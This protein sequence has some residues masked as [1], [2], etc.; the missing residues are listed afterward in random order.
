MR[1][2]Q[3]GQ[4]DSEHA[5]WATAE[6]YH[7]TP[8]GP[9][10]QTVT[11]TEFDADNNAVEVE[12]G[13]TTGFVHEVCL[14]ILKDQIKSKLGQVPILLSADIVWTHVDLGTDGSGTWETRR[15]LTIWDQGDS[16]NWRYDKSLDLDWYLDK[17]HIVRG[18]DVEAA[19]SDTGTWTHVYGNGNFDISRMPLRTIVE[20]ALRDNTHVFAHLSC[21]HVPGAM[22]VGRTQVIFNPP[23]I[24]SHRP[25]LA[26]AYLY[27]IE[28]YRDDGSG[29]LDLASPVTDTPGDEYYLGAVEPG[30]TGVAKKCHLRNYSDGIQQ[31]EIFDDHPEYTVPI[32]RVGTSQLD[33][34]GLADN[35]VSQLYTAIFYSSTQFEVKAVAYRDNAISLHPTINADASWRGAVGSDFTAPE[36]GLIIPSAAWQ[37]GT[38]LDDEYEAGVRGNTTD[39]AW[40]ADSNDQ[41]EITKDNAGSPDATAWRPCLGRRELTRAQVTID[42]TTKMIPTR[43]V[44]PANW[45]VDTKAFIMDET[46][47]NEGEI[48]SVQEMSVGAASHVG[49]GLDDCTISGNFNGVWTDTL[50]IRIDGTGTPDTF[51]ISYDGGSTYPTQDVPMTGAAQLLKDGLYVTFAATT[52]HTLTDYWNS[53]IEAWAIELKALTANSNV[54]NSGSR[55]ATT[56]PI[57]DVPASTFS[58]VDAASGVSEGTPARIWVASTVGMSPGQD[59]FIQNPVDPGTAEVREI[60]SVQAGSYIDVTVALT[61]DYPIGSFVAV[62]D[63]GQEAFWARPI[64]GITTTEEL[65]RLRFNARML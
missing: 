55:I 9:W 32:T 64:A 63:S 12:L 45:P 1:F 38:A 15:M 48:A 34:I 65:K 53:A 11:D 61:Q 23:T 22:P 43:R 31:V 47:I 5:D 62:V 58:T 29:D 3:W 20:R 36:G 37:P 8:F 10:G 49:S 59:V 25:Y 60:D 30:Q 18:Q 35:A 27:P 14:R 16:S 39:S 4:A 2:W 52:G 44:I 33:Y 42:A 41:V 57:R 28:F 21:Y 17:K 6:T 19:P 26:F 7:R 46:N 24:F 50:R 54:Y 40:P 56:L 13:S 51:E